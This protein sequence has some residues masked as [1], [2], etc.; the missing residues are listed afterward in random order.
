VIKVRYTRHIFS[1]YDITATRNQRLDAWI[2]GTTLHL[3]YSYDS[4]W[5]F[6]VMPEWNFL[7]LDTGLY[8]EEKHSGTVD[9]YIVDDAESVA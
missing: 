7:G 1:G 2:E 5:G 3:K 4:P 9:V 8:D 6:A